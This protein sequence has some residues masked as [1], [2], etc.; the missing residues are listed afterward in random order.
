[1]AAD[2]NVV[3]AILSHT[4]NQLIMVIYNDKS[5]MH[6]SSQFYDVLC[7]KMYWTFFSILIVIIYPKC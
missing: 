2:I 5:Q 3:F 7:V 1:M 6:M 4:T